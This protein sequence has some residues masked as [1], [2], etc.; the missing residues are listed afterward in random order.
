[1][2]HIVRLLAVLALVS[3][4]VPDAQA[5]PGR[6]RAYGGLV[7]GEEWLA[8]AGYELKIPFVTLVP[9]AEYVFLDKSYVSLNAD[10]Q[11]GFLPIPLVDIWIG[12]GAGVAFFTPPVGDSKTY[13]LVNL[14]A[15]VGTDII[16]L[17]PYVQYKF[18]IKEEKDWSVLTFGIRF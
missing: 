8:G 7:E 6:L 17:S 16:P 13:G 5:L 10:A 9:N 2:K 12:A 3:A 14:F 15:G 4:V 1:M 18:V 11:F